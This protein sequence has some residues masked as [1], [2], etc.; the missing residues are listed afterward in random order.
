MMDDLGIGGLPDG[1]SPIV[2]NAIPGASIG[3]SFQGT[4]VNTFAD[5]GFTVVVK[6]TDA[7]G[8][9]LPGLSVT[10]SVD[11]NNGTP[12]GAYITPGF[13]PTGTTGLD[14]TVSIFVAVHKAG[15]FILAANGTFSDVSTQTGL[16][17][18]FQVQNK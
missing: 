11:N 15:G 6:A 8:Q 1:W 3:L 2:P 9:P 4:I 10:I 16:S 5:S 18:Q 17:N 13:N 7:S 12:A 14:G